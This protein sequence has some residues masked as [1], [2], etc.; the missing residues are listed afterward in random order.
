MIRPMGRG[1]EPPP[2]IQQVWATINPAHAIQRVSAALVFS[3]EIPFFTVKKLADAIRV[4]AASQGMTQEAPLNTMLIAVAAGGIPQAKSDGQQ[5]TL[6][7]QQQAGNL[8]QQVMLAR[9]MINLTSMAYV[10]WVGF[11]DQLAALLRLVAPIVELSVELRQ[12]TLEY[13]DVFYARDPGPAN[14]G[15]ILNGS[16][17]VLNS[18]AFSR[19]DPFHSNSG[20]F[21][22]VGQERHL[23]NADIAASDADGPP[24]RRRMVT[25]RTLE[26]IVAEPQDANANATAIVANA[27][28]LLSSFNALH[29]SLKK[30]I[31]AILTKEAAAMISLGS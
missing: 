7:Q 17:R 3:E 22:K 8:V 21:K 4:W 2:T 9:E 5:G 29:V 16:S 14:A 15:L 24:G 31:S 20:W 30:R 6:F 12:V 1:K 18:Q 26:A 27:D 13:V 25:V 11:R 19:L 28:L 10:R 23:I